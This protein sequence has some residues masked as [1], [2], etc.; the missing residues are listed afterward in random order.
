MTNTINKIIIPKKWTES[1]ASSKTKE[2][3]LRELKNISTEDIN[4][5][6]EAILESKLN[7]TEEG[8]EK[9]IIKDEE[10]PEERILMV[11][12][13]LL[14]LGYSILHM[15]PIMAA[16]KPI[17]ICK[18]WNEIFIYNEYDQIW[19]NITWVY[20]LKDTKKNTTESV[21]T[22]EWRPTL[23]VRIW[24]EDIILRWEDQIDAG[25]FFRKNEE[26][27]TYTVQEITQFLESL[28]NH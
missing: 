17:F 7:K 10:Y 12:E 5:V 25:I 9:P 6:W 21:I 24:F 3:L 26:N 11:R 23:V 19:K 8:K 28:W 22:V 15:D 2:E 13:Y 14:R 18:R 27:P 1:L 16:W 20:G 4:N